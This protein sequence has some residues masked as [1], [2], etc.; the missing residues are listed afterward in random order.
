MS[1]IFLLYLC[2]MKVLYLHGLDSSLQ[3][4]RRAALERYGEVAAPQLSYRSS[5][6]LLEQ[7]ITEYATVDALV[8][9]SAGGLVAYYLAQL[10]A[11]PALLL[12]PALPFREEVPADLPLPAD[13]R[14]YMRVVIGL[15]D[16]VVDPWTSVAVLKEDSTR[17]SA[18]DIVLLGAMEHSYPIEIFEEQLAQFIASSF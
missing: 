5:P 1:F 12:N 18:L 3:S 15:R 10:L 13:H 14:A 2:A 16:A 11:K 6:H 8:G 7:L 9:S 4:D 17:L